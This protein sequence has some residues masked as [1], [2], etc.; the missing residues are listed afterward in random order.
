M[1]GVVKRNGQAERYMDQLHS[2]GMDSPSAKEVPLAVRGL[3]CPR[4]VELS[5]RPARARAG[6]DA[7]HAAPLGRPGSS[8][9]AGYATIVDAAHRLDQMSLSGP[10]ILLS[11]TCI[12]LDGSISSN[13][14]AAL[15]Q[16]MTRVAVADR[17]GKRHMNPCISV[18]R[19]GCFGIELNLCWEP[20][21][22]VAAVCI[23]MRCIILSRD[24]PRREATS[25]H[26]RGFLYRDMINRIEY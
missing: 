21:P 4:G 2:N 25:A 19:R 14:R 1:Q 17:P 11:S 24:T 10:N 8:S 12:T 9:A 5:A 13:T 26:W 15:L 20:D 22:N 3:P 7:D 6:L 18:V 23:T 16:S